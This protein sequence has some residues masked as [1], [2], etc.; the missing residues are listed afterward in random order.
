M[1]PHA[2]PK[3]LVLIIVVAGFG[4][5]TSL[6]QEQNVAAQSTNSPGGPDSVAPLP[7]IT[8]IDA[9]VL[10]REQLEAEVR[11]R[12]GQ[13]RKWEWK[14]PI[15]FYG[16]VVDENG[17]PIGAADVRMQWTNF[18]ANGTENRQMQSDAQ[19]L[20]S[21]DNVTGK[22]L[23]VRVSKPGYYA[24]DSRNRFSFEYANP[25]EEI[26]HRPDPNRPVFFFLRRQNPA[27][28]VISKSV[29]V[30]LPGDGTG[31]R[32]HL[33]S[34]KVAATGEVQI[35]AWK[36]W[37]PRPMSPPYNWKVI[38]SIAG[39][40]FVETHEDF[41]FEAPEAGYEETYMIDMNP[42]LLTEWRVSAEHSLYF[43]FGE[44][45]KYGRMSLRTDGGSRYIFLD[46]VINQSG[47]RNLESAETHR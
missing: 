12:D 21:I 46:Y 44:P 34:G 9:A 38:L 30:V 31:P 2:F 39:G 41:A 4:P 29:E 16:R 18:S 23:V 45:K 19:G 33:E 43:T 1:I 35:Q 37:P 36:P 40:G 17:H 27:A 42:A 25:F 32:L 11:R 47:S 6:P 15:K 26:F 3:Q 10:S 5:A 28:D 14:I 20:F 8:Q 24:S 22:R 7:K 13:D